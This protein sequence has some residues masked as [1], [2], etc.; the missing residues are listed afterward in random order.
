MRRRLRLALWTAAHEN[1]VAAL[2]VFI[3]PSSALDSA[4]RPR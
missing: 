1:Y 3:R 2:V 4:D